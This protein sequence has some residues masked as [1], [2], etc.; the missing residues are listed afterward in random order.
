M[1]DS[2]KATR[3]DVLIGSFIAGGFKLPDQTY[4]MS[5]AP[6]TLPIASRPIGA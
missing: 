5:L 6:L 1:I 3:A 2:T 4:R